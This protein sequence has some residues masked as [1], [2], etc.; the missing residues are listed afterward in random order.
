MNENDTFTVLYSG[1]ISFP[2]FFFRCCYLYSF[3]AV[4]TMRCETRNHS[5]LKHYVHL[6]SIFRRKDG[7]SIEN[8]IVPIIYSFEILYL[9]LQWNVSKQWQ[10]YVER[11]YSLVASCK[12]QIENRNIANYTNIEHIS[13]NWRFLYLTSTNFHGTYWNW[14]LDL[15]E[16]WL[17]CVRTLL[18]SNCF[19][20][21]YECTILVDLNCVWQSGSMLKKFPPFDEPSSMSNQLSFFFFFFSRSHPLHAIFTSLYTVLTY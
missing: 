9:K 5:F 14:Q 4:R 1:L 15:V 10:M 20:Q 11:E 17:C 13:T 6:V 2:L 19:R 21:M 12:N 3:R 8:R 16:C 18:V 7:I